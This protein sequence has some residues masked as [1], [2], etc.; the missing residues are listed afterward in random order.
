M[1]QDQW[2]LCWSQRQ[3]A[4]H[5]EPFERHIQANREALMEGRGGDY[6]LLAVGT[7]EEVDAAA[8]TLRPAVTTGEV[9]AR[10]KEVA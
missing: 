7:R 8:N 2:C 10:A 6:R 3:N 5:V 4:L 1:N 9:I